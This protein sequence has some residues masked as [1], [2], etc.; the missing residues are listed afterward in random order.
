MIY[1]LNIF[2]KTIISQYI[3]EAGVSPKTADPVGIIASHIFA[4]ADFKWNGVSLI[5]VFL[6]KYRVVCPVLFGT[7]GSESTDHGRQR[8]GWWR[9]GAG[10]PFFSQQRHYERMTGLGA[11]FAALSLRNYEKSKLTNPF[12]DFHYWEA[13][14]RIA[15]VPSAE[16]TPTHFVVLK[17]MIENYESKFI[18]F[19]G[20][21]AVAAL[22]HVLVELPKR[23]APASASKSLAGLVEILKKDK[24]LFL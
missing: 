13:L 24:K 15:N 8:L 17:G 22:R 10:G 14:A 11:G 2:S 6:A 20:G 16:L 18:G 12:P 21:A 19:Y 9:E 4:Q 1:L 23:V 7:Y 5:D 3:N